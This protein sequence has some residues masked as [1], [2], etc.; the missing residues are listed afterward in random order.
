MTNVAKHTWTYRSGRASAS[1]F[2][3]LDDHSFSRWTALLEQRVGLY[4]APERKSFLM[5]GLRRRM[6]E[7]GFDTYRDYYEWLRDGITQPKE[8]SLLIDILTVHETRFFRHQSSM[9]LVEEYIL[10]EALQRSDSFRA[11]SVGCA[12]GEEVYSLAML[13]DDH[14]YES[15]ARRLYGVTGTDISLQALKKARSGVYRS[16]HLGNIKESYREKYCKPVQ[17]GSFEINESLRER[18]CF[19]HLNLRDVGQSPLTGLDLIYC[20]NLM[21]YFSRE[22]RIDIANSL[23]ERLRGGGVLVLGPGELLHWQNP[24]MEKMRY[25]D[26]LAYRRVERAQLTQI[27]RN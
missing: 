15:G 21:I 23:A 10:P 26:T 1:V 18:V 4:I 5:A 25:D 8:W 11:W 17:S 20:Q 2:P 14:C 16:K 3:E 19:A 12:T 27:G 13:L 9:C 22:R 6:R 7:N 24:C